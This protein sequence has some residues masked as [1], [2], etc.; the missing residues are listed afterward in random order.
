MKKNI[1]LLFFLSLL[2]T[3]SV[4]SAD[5]SGL[6]LPVH[7]G[8]ERSFDSVSGASVIIVTQ[9]GYGT[10]TVVKYKKKTYVLTAKHVVAPM[11][12][13][14]VSPTII[15]ESSTATASVIYRDSNSDI[16]VLSLTSDIEVKPYK[17]SFPRRDTKL[18]DSVGYCGYP[19]RR[20]LSCFTGRVSGFPSGYVNIHSYAFSGA[21]GSL[22]VDSAGRAVGILSA[23][24]VGQFLGI[25]QALESVVWVVPVDKHILEGL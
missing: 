4:T 14:E 24:E 11:F 3:S 9:F 23:V 8:P 2:F 22:V 16:A 15:K 17:I 12:G 25:P 18:G 13:E 7:S 21:S 19:N 6:T 1:F 10:G 20:D 5:D